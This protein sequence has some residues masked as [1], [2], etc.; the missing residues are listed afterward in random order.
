MLFSI[1]RF[2]LF[3]VAFF[4]I[5]FESEMNWK[6]SYKI[7]KLVVLQ[8]IIWPIDPR[9]RPQS[10]PVVITIFTQKLIVQ[11]LS[12]VKCNYIWHMDF[13]FCLHLY[14]QFPT[15]TGLFRYNYTACSF[16]Q[17]LLTIWIQLSCSYDMSYVITFDI[18]EVR[19]MS[20]GAIN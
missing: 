16:L 14:G 15:T 20:Y 10:R 19:S 3:Q 2:W 13:N 9:G 4:P 6:K 17:S 11:S 18:W 7:D 5:R 12:Y 8:M 1:I